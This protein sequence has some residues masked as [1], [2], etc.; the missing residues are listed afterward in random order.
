M[1]RTQTTCPA[2]HQPVIVEIQQLFDLTQEPQAKQ[3]LLSNA[4]NAM[5]CPACGY[6]GMVAVPVVYHDP[7]KEML[8]TF[9]PPNLNAPLNEQEKQIGPLIN[10]V[11]TALPQEKRKAYLLQPQSMF[12]YQTLIEKILEADGI[13]KEMLEEQK[14]RIKLLEKLLTSPKEGRLQIIK[15]EEKLFDIGFFTVFSRIVQS[16]VAQGD[17]SSKKELLE[18][19]QLLFENTQVG[20]DLYGQAKE[21]ESALK[22]LR[23]A[24]KEGLTRE[25]LLDLIITTKSDIGLSTVVSYARSGMDYAFFQLLSEKIDHTTDKAEKE[26]FTGLREKLLTMTDEIDKR[27]K[28]EFENSKTLLESILKAENIEEE[29][30]KNIESVS[31]FFVQNLESELSL[32][33]KKGDLERINKLEQVM[34]VIEKV[35]SPS[36]GVKLLEAMLV[37]KTEEEIDT[38]LTE[39]KDRIT[40]EFQALLNNVIAQTENQPSQ[41]EVSDKLRSIFRKVLRFTMKANMEKKD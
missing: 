41:K 5:H 23:E 2:C 1:P 13:T 3:K 15:E 33:R 7:E 27:V 31:D 14:K 21:T 20:K 39:N 32:A 22:A 10:R 24:G 40:E 16:T 29:V 4:V 36:D 19:Q 34:V 28:E 9:F 25:K 35:S 38:L 26:N 6:Q 30:M 11:M 8:L 37:S 18:L 12:T 17:E